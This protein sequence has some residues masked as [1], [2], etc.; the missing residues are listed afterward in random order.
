MAYRVEMTALAED[1][2][3]SMYLWLKSSQ[4]VE[5]A[6]VWYN[7][8]DA[9]IN[10]LETFP[11]RCPVAPEGREFGIEV[12]QLLHGNRRSAYRI[13]FHIKSVSEIEVVRVLRIRHS[14]QKNLRFD[15]LDLN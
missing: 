2:L 9:A 4:S 3:E 8:M 13:I 6:N 1:D 5:I 14:A 11:N 7:Q 15:E 10:S 12:R